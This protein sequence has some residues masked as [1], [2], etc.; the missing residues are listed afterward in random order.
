MIGN[1]LIFCIKAVPKFK[2]EFSKNAFGYFTKIIFRVFINQ[3]TL[4]KTKNKKL[5][6]WKD[7]EYEKQIIEAGIGFNPN[8][9]QDSKKD[10]ILT[11]DEESEIYYPTFILDPKTL[12]VQSIMQ[13]S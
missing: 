7:R 2:P 10:S 11:N 1:A 3:I 8:M 6:D 4:F 9:V 5:N 13:R 12:K